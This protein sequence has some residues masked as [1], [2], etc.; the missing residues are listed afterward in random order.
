MIKYFIQQ[1][2]LG[3]LQSLLEIKL[4]VERIN[5]SVH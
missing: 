5:K 2:K 4:S 1:Y 3:S